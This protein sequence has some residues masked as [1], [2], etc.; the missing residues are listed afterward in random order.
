MKNM[1]LA[2]KWVGDYKT[3][4]SFSVREGT[5]FWVWGR[6]TQNTGIFQAQEFQITNLHSSLGIQMTSQEWELQE[7]TITC[8]SIPQ[9]GKE[10]LQKE[11][12]CLRIVS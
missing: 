3:L 1:Q 2:G 4:C 9:M 11:E 6:Q 10:A 7:T 5:A 12:I 8:S